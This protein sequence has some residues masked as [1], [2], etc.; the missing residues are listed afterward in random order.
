LEKR[1]A[2]VRYHAVD[3]EGIPVRDIAD[4][5]G[6]GLKV[7][8]VSLSLEEATGHFE[9]LAMFA[10]LDFRLQVR[11]RRNDWDGTRPALD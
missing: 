6:R 8:V 2:G 7:P 11:E 9:W 4:V 1:E 5:I 10:G 3:E